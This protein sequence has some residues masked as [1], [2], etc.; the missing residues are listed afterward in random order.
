MNLSSSSKASRGLSWPELVPAT[1]LKRYKRFL[2]EALVT[3]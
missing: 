1:L 3:K 2:A